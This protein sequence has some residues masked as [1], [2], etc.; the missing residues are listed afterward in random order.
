MANEN[1]ISRVTT[2]FQRYIFHFLPGLPVLVGI[3]II[4][5][6]SLNLNLSEISEITHELQLSSSEGLLNFT[7]FLVILLLALGFVFLFGMIVDAIRH[8]IEEMFLVP[9]WSEYKVARGIKSKDD[10]IKNVG[11]KWD[12]YDKVH[13]TEYYYIEFFGNVAISLA[14]LWG[15]I[16][17]TRKYP[18]FGYCIVW[19]HL[20]FLVR[21]FLAPVFQKWHEW[22]EELKKNYIQPIKENSSIWHSFFSRV[23]HGFKNVFINVVF[24]RLWDFS[25]TFASIFFLVIYASYLPKEAFHFYFIGAIMITASFELYIVR[26]KRYQEILK[27]LFLNSKE[28][29]E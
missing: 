2:P 7:F 6:T 4:L 20:V 1:S 11:R 13:E 17:V 26:F 27:A 14:F 19:A 21:P 22:A 29:S 8:M 24:L 16:V 18:Y 3:C 25:A 28:T 23:W 12:I 15:I 5:W 9:K 10:T